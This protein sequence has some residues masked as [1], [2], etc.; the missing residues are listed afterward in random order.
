MPTNKYDYVCIYWCNTSHESHVFW[1]LKCVC[2]SKIK[3]LSRWIM[4]FLYKLFVQ[5]P[6]LYPNM[7]M[8]V[9]LYASETP[10][11]SFS[12]G[13]IEIHVPAAAKFSAVKPDGSLVPLFRLDV[14]S[15]VFRY[16]HYSQKHCIKKVRGT[17]KYQNCTKQHKLQIQKYKQSY[18][19]M[20][21]PNL[22]I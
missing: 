9:L 7:E 11:C 14:V 10:L 2:S 6:T 1:C 3:L 22:S 15:F 8:Q 18:K 13:L 5:L 16:T 4:W 20:C 17:H 21:S 12:P 19:T